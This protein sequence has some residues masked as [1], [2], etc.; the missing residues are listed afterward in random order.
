MKQNLDLG[1]K[2]YFVSYGVVS[3]WRHMCRVVSYWYD[4]THLD[5]LPM[6][7]AA[8]H[9]GMGSCYICH[10]VVI[11]IVME[12]TSSMSFFGIDIGNSTFLHYILCDNTEFSSHSSEIRGSSLMK[13]PWEMLQN[14]SYLIYI[15][16]SQ[17]KFFS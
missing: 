9:L 16:I 8:R 15:Y 6:T 5:S 12:N 7:T 14:L 17:L 13:W 2:K 4:T 11:L 3:F 10:W 1:W